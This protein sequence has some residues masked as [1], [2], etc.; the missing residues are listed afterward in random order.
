MGEAY[1]TC[2]EVDQ[3]AHQ[4]PAAWSAGA[5]EMA[6]IRSGFTSR[7]TAV[8]RPDG[9]RVKPAAPEEPG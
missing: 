1:Q 8:F 5:D 3:V 4:V 2:Q 9:N 6:W 7:E